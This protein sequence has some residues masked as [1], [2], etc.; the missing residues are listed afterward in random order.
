MLTNK[1]DPEND[2]MP[3]ISFQHIHTHVQQI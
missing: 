2:S 3:N 1:N